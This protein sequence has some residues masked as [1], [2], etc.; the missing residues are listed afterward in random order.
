MSSLFEIV[1]ERIQFEDFLN[2]PELELDE[3]AFMDTW[4]SLEGETNSKVAAWAAW[5]TRLENDV[6][7]RKEFIADLEEKNTADTNKINHMKA[8]LKMIM[9]RLNIKKAGN[10]IISVTLCANGGKLPLLWADGIKEDARLL[11]EKYQKVETIYKPNT[12]LIREDLDAG[13]AV[14]GV[15]YG[16]RGSYLRIK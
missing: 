14:P 16:Q 11:P 9:E 4:E 2:D 1:G 12:D 8:V 7:S 5:I 15:E 10:E 13:I 6:N 3:Q